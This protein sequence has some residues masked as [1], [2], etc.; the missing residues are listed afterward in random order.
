[1]SLAEDAC[2]FLR[3]TRHGVLATH[4][5]R[6]TGYP[7]GSVAPF[8]LDHD[9]CP[10]ILISTLAEHTRNIAADPRVSLL[11]FA[12][13][14]DLQAAARLTLIGDAELA[15]KHDALLRARYLRYLPQ[16]EQYFDTHDFLFHRIRI[17][18]ARF[19]GGFGKIAW[20]AAAELRPP[21]N[22]L[23]GQE[24]AILDHMNADH[25]DN[26]REFCRHL[27]GVD[28]GDAT[29]IGIDSYGFD[30]NADGAVL[31]CDFANPITDAQGARAALVGMLKALR[32]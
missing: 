10:I 18:Q 4:S 5:A 23:A 26:L 29:M 1:M 11:A 32:P 13:A 28:P 17:N 16:A 21:A 20:I 12:P 8:V 27:H 2:R 24:A 9:G 15:D 30:I 7:F 6:L 22:Q 25:A 3:S 19:I 31:R 14:D